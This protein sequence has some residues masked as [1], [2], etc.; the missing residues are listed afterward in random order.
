MMA[1]FGLSLVT[2]CFGQKNFVWE[3][4]DTSSKTKNQLYSDTKM[5]IADKWNSAQNVIQNDDKEGGNI[6]IKGLTQK[7]RVNRGLSVDDYTFSYTIKFMFKENKY[8][9]VI[10]DVRCHSSW[11]TTN[12]TTQGGCT[13]VSET[14]PTEKG[15]ALTGLASE[16]KYLDLMGRLKEDIQGIY[17]EYIKYISKKSAE[18]N[19]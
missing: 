12:T 19:W 15:F 13:I 10:D 7:I 1:L 4:V 2:S 18:N 17:D 9:M 14:Y 8:R 16:K 6:L 3:K 5:F 11:V